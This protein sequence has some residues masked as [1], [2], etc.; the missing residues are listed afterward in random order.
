MRY[1]ERQKFNLPITTIAVDY[2]P[3]DIVTWSPSP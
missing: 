3:G 1:F 2:N